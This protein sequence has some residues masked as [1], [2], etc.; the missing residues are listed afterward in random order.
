M[1][2]RNAPEFD[3]LSLNLFR[4]QEHPDK[5]ALVGFVARDWEAVP[6]AQGGLDD[7]AVQEP[8]VL[9]YGAKGEDGVGKGLRVDAEVDWGG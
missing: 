2:R 8:V 9:G 1:Q 3:P 4:D 5:V 6:V 7:M